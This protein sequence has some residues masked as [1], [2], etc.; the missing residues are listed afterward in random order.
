MKKI[1]I[2]C[3]KSIQNKCGMQLHPIQEV[4]NAKIL[5]DSNKDEMA[6]SNNPDFVSAIKYIGK[7]QNVETEFFLDGISC[8]DDIEPIF[9]DFNKALDMINEFGATE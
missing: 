7:K 3:G 2:Y 1:K 9:A 6:Y 8:G 4:E 5:I